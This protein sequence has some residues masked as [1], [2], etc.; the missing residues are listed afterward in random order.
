[1]DSRPVSST[2][3]TSLPIF[4]LIYLISDN[5]VPNGDGAPDS[6]RT[7]ISVFTA[8][9]LL[10]ESKGP[11]WFYGTG[12]EH[13]ALYQYQLYGAKDVGRVLSPNKRVATIDKVQQIYLGHIQAETPYY[14]PAPLATEPFKNA[15]SF[16]G[17][18]TFTDCYEG[19]GCNEAWGLRVIDSENIYIHSAGLYSF[20]VDY[21]QST[22]IDAFNCQ[23]RMTHVSGARENSVVIF[24]LFTIG[25]GEPATG[26]A[27]LSI[28]Q[29]DTQR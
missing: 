1:M 13:S 16:P 24:N 19:K 17:D 25:V 23:K 26:A 18:P 28:A 27:G 20:F 8:R 12:A 11:C 21:N 6:S 29:K 7:R 2:I 5:D 10:I 9:A 14:Q 4:D 3:R 22:C 15:A